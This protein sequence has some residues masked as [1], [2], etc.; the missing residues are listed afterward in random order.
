L[1][2]NPGRKLHVPPEWEAA[3][4]EIFERR[5]RTVL[6]IGGSAVGKSSFCRYLA[7]A[8]LMRQAEVAFVDA[9]IGQ[10]NLG[11]PAAVTLGYPALPVDFW[12]TLPAAFYFVGSTGPI[13][14][15][16]PL[17]VGTADLAR[18]ARGAFVIIDT[19]GLVHES[20]RVLKNYKIEA[21][22]PDVIVAVERRREL[23]PIRMANR[24]V[25]IIRIEP[26]HKAHGKDD[27]EKI[28]V[29]RRSYARHF[30]GASVL[31]LPIDPL[32]FQRT[33]LFSGEP[34]ELD[35]AIHAE[36]SADGMLIVGAPVAPPPD[37][38]LLPGGF[39]RSLLCGIADATARCLGLG[40][41]ERIE[42]TGRT[43]TLTTAVERDK[44]RIIQ[45]GDVYVT[46]DGAELGQVKWAW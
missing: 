21:V 46:P 13:G 41:I 45:F 18:E 35:G 42:F 16:L 1:T 22:R 24:H 10:S 30:A 34:I 26:S 39:E 17:V 36:R 31:E 37:S 25:P 8:L 38:K 5:L 29:R 11:P 40:I 19:T 27:Y 4:A 33:L 14:R 7:G 32:I 9:D 3:A 43:I 2:A 6:V 23:A 12:A 20:G 28:E 44:V 15:F